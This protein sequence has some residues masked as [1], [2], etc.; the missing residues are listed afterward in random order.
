LES[1]AVIEDIIWK[2]LESSAKRRRYIK[3]I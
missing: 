3:Q 2:I 1:E